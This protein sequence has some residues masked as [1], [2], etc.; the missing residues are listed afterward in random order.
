MQVYAEDSATTQLND[1]VQKVM[2]Y[3]AK[4]KQSVIN[5]QGQV[6]EE[7]TGTFVLERPGK[8]R[9]D[10]VEPFPQQIVADGQR[11]WFYDVDL[12]QVT[13]K[14]QQEALA[15]T[16]ATLLSGQALP[17]DKYSLTEIE[18]DDG[19]NWIQLIPKNQESNYQTITLAFDNAGLRQML[20]KDSFD[21]RTRL[22]FS[23]AVEN[24]DLDKDTFVFQAPEGVD[25]VGDQ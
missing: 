19:F 9:W 5:P 23:Q 17:E 6:I 3:Q 11:I 16:P 13:V 4:F 10:Y 20:M 12:E 14:S 24:A 8:F 18:T 7:A 22:V 15:D 21:Q 25:V 1:F 2:T